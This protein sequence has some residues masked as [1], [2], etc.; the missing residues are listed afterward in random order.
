MSVFKLSWKYLI[1]RPL[2]TILNVL[3]LALGLSII[4][5]LLLVEEQF[6]N[7]VNRD[8]AGIDMVIG[9]KGSPLQLVLSSVYHVDFPTGNIPLK[10]AQKVSRNR[11]IKNAIPMALGDN[12][13]GFRIVGSNHDYLNIYQA[14]LI[15]GKKWEKPFE[16]VVGSKVAKA[17]G[18][19]VGD[20]FIGAHGIEAASHQ[21]DQHAFQVVGILAPSNNV[22]DQLIVTSVE[23]VWYA[24]DEEIGSEKLENQ[25]NATGF[26]ES[27]ETRELTTVLIAYRSPMAAIQLPRM[28]NGRTTLQAASPTFEMSRLF[29]LLG[30]GVVVMKGLALLIIF[31]AGLGIFIALYNSMKERKYDLAVMRAIGAAKSQLFLLILSEGIILT[32]L[33]AIGGLILGHFFLLLIVITNEQGLVAGLNAITFTDKEWW[34]IV[35]A[36]MVGVLA[37]IIP[38]W[39]AYKE[40]IAGQLSK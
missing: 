33:G 5:V 37:S 22:L 20:T 2:N 31:I 28:I 13:E 39:N 10:E 25:V 34:V 18:F 19:K 38:A 30:I 27:D 6:E 36:L 14:E 23:S 3:L 1:D 24:H 26:P 4:T 16:V 7:K 35:Y 11:L 8:A 15:D 17:K 29:E 12:Y 40:D 21:H 32:F 9:A